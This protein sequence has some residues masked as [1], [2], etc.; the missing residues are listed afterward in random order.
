MSAPPVAWALDERIAGTSLEVCDLE[1]C[2]VRLQDDA[3][4]PWLVL[5]P[6]LPG[7]SELEDLPA[8]DR[9]RLTEEIV[10]AGA[11]VRAAGGA[12]GVAVDKLNVGALGNI[13]P[14]LHVHVVGR[15][16]EGDPAG[17]GPVWGVGLAQA[18]PEREREKAL[19][20]ARAALRG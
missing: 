19:A 1:L 15:R 7:L 16:R 6:R 11:A 5:I 14:Q 2:H 18:W 4:W 12:A 9:A 10:R 3:R 20:A 17:A 13:V 8:A